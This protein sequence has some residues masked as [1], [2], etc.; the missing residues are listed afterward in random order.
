ML[1][2]LRSQ[3]GIREPV[4]WGDSAVCAGGGGDAGGDVGG[5]DGDALG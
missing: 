4:P 3:S 1:G 2:L 5:Y